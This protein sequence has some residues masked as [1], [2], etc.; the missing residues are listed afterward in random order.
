M[1]GAASVPSA[2]IALQQTDIPFC[3]RQLATAGS[4]AP[5]YDKRLNDRWRKV[6]KTRFTVAL[7]LLAGAAL[8]A[9]AV[10]G[11]HAQAKPKAYILTESEVLDAA[12]LA[13]YTPKLREVQK[14]HGARLV[15]PAGGKVVAS[16]GEPP[17]RV[18]VTEY[19]NVE[20]AQGYLTSDARKAL[21]PEREKAVKIIRQYIVEGPAN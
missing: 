7:S 20:K 2:G 13:A 19:E 17:K 11:L 9:A 15:F 1:G 21:A 18:G 4:C 8:G 10:Q 3:R 12:A 6:M 14:A 5:A 16:V